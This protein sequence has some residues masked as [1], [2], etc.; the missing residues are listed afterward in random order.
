MLVEIKMAI[1][2]RYLAGGEY[3]DIREMWSIRTQ[4]V[5]K[6]IEHVI[7]R[8]AAIKIMIV[9]VRKTF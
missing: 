2:L 5:Y 3:L 4:T 1:T 9:R 7:P 8:I 6:I